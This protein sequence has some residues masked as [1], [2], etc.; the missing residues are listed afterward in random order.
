MEKKNEHYCDICKKNYKNYKSLWKHNYV[1]HKNTDNHHNHIDNHHN[2][3]DN[4]KIVLKNEEAKVYLCNKCNK[5]F[6][7]YQNRWRHEKKCKNE[8]GKKED[9]KI[10][11]LEDKVLKANEENNELK[12]TVKK[13]S[14]DFEE[15]KKLIKKADKQIVNNINNGNINNG[16]IINNHIQINAIGCE[17]LIKKLSDTQ[18]LDV[19][20]AGLFDESPIVELVRKTYNDEKLK[21]NRNTYISNL[22]SPNCLTYNNEKKRFDAVNKNKHIDNIIKNRMDDIIKMYA[23]HSNKMKPAHKKIFNEYIENINNNENNKNKELY[24]KHKEEINRIIYNDKEFMKKV[25]EIV[26]KTEIIENEEDSEAEEI[27]DQDS[28]DSV[29]L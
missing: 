13:I 3:N 12:E 21:K 4:H 6:E 29:V 10:K 15:M 27:E 26:D 18:Q 11:D 22:Q 2:H 17:D 7:F 23:A 25:K 24:Q 5:S 20:T 1:F 16:N 28:E 9:D 8:G 19:L 14:K